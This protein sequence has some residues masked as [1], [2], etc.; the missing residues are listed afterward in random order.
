[1]S[2]PM[3]IALALIAA[4]TGL[5]VGPADADHRHRDRPDTIDLPDG[6]F[7][8]GIAI[9]R[10][11]AYVGSLNDGAIEVLDLRRGTATEFA[12]SPGD[13]RIAVGMDVD[14]FGRLWVAGGG[15][16]FPGIVPGYRVYDTRTGALLADV[17]LPQAGFINDVYVTRNAAWFTDSFTP[18]LTRVPI[19]R[20]GAIGR[21]EP[22]A[23]EGDW[24]Q[25]QGFS[26]NGIVATRGGRHLVVAQS[27]GPEGGPAYY[28]VPAERSAD[29][30]EAR[31]IDVDGAPS[32]ADGLVLVG[33][34]LYSVGGG[35]VTELRLS[36]NLE[37]AE[38]TEILEVPGALTPT[39][40]DLF[41]GR[42]YVVDAKFPLSGDPT[43]PYQVTAIRR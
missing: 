36:R 35:A 33:R 5:L 38:V 26:A 28:V 32:G 29:R 37:R 10:G 21:P 31:R 2:K 15:V 43:T 39:T 42:L 17:E 6:F 13:D 4:L 7:P 16:A 8:E 34:T 27:T 30:V 3:A 12:P 1:M 19:G 24:I 41:R 11:K 9:N 22:V 20:K 23:I 40:A 25:T 18:V 14:R